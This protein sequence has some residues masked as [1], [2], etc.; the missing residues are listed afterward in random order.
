MVFQKK[1]NSF[2]LLS[3]ILLLQYF[4]APAESCVYF[5][6][7]IKAESIPPKTSCQRMPSRVTIIM[8]SVLCD[9]WADAEKTC[10]ISKE[11]IRYFIPKIINDFLNKKGETQDKFRLGINE[12]NCINN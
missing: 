3:R 11:R 12:T 2:F 9:D 1:G 5:L 4:A 6:F 7:I 10:K 8:F